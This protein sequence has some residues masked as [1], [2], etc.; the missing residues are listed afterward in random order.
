MKIGNNKD[1]FLAKEEK[2]KTFKDDKLPQQNNEKGKNYETTFVNKITSFIPMFINGFKSIDYTK[3]HQLSNYFK[4]TVKYYTYGQ[5]SDTANFIKF[6]YLNQKY[7]K[8]YD[9]F[10]NTSSS[11]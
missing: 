11:P 10:F 7:N 9:L 2:I 5:N 3:K 8:L 1:V 6:L 4:L